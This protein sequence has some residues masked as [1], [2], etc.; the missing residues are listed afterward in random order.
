MALLGEY[1]HTLGGISIYVKG[2]FNQ[3]L[4]VLL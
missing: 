3:V 1:S 2:E 4:L